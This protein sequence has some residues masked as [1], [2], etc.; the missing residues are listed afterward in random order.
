MTVALSTE[1][2]RAFERSPVR[3]SPARRQAVL[4]P[5]GF[6]AH[7]CAS[8]RRPRI[9]LREVRSYLPRARRAYAL[10]RRL[11]AGD[12]HPAGVIDVDDQNARGNKHSV[13]CQAV[14]GDVFF[15]MHKVSL[16]WLRVRHL[17]FYVALQRKLAGDERSLKHNGGQAPRAPASVRFC[18]SLTACIRRRS[19]DVS[20]TAC[21]RKH[22]GDSFAA[23]AF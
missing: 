15:R 19:L 18:R 22:S 17:L 10:G 20:S 23:N 13:V 8:R 2:G 4:V 7:V 3:L 5:P 11:A 16:A 1:Y 9:S 14:H 12:G 6:F 21:V